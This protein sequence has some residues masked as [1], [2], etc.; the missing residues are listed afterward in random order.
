MDL[1][2]WKGRVTD[3]LRR[4]ARQARAEVERSGPHLLYGTLAGMA[5][6]PVAE[7][8]QGGELAALGA[9]YSLGAGVGVNLLANQVQ[10]WKD[11]ADA[12][13]KLARAA[14]EDAEV[15]A[16]LDTV[17]ARLEV[18]PTLQAALSDDD[19]DWFVRLLGDELRRSGS[20]LVVSAAGRGIAQ[21]G[22]RNIAISGDVEGGVTIVQGDADR[23]DPAALRQAYLCRLVAQTRGLPLIGVDP[24]AASDAD[25]ADLE[26]AAVYTALLTQRREG[27]R[28][29]L[30]LPG[31][32]RETRR[33]SAVEMLNAEPHL[34]L[35]G[36]PG[37]GKSTFVNFVALCLAGEALG[38]GRANVELLTAP[39]PDEGAERQRRTDEELRP[40]PWDH[41]ALLPV[42]V[43]LRDLAARG[44]PP[45]GRRAS[46]DDLWRFLTAEL[47]ETLAEYAPHLKRELQE[48]GGLVLLDGLDE[49]PE[50]DSRREQAKQVVVSFA[51]DFPR[52]RFLVTSRTYAYQ[53]QEWKLP[54]FVEAVLAPFGPGQ[55]ERFVDRWY[56]HIATLRNL[57]PDDA[58]G[59]A[60]VLKMAIHRS[61]RLAD[62]A[63]RPVLLTLMASLHAWRGGS[64]PEKREELYADVVDLLLDQWERAKVVRDARGQPLLQQPSLTEWL[65]VDRQV[66]RSLLNRLAFESHRDQPQL[67]GT[68]DLSQARVVDGLMTAARNPEVNPAQ[69]VVYVRDRAGLLAARGEGV[70]AFPHRSFQ[71]YLAACHLTDHGFPDELA[72]LLRAD[73]E[74]W[75]EVTLLAAAKSARGT[76]FA[77]WSLVDALCYGE[78]SATPA[79]ADFWAALLAARALVETEQLAAVSAPNRAK[80]ERLRCWLVRLVEGG[81]LPPVDRALAGDALAVLGDPRFDPG[82]FWLPCRFR[83]DPELLLGFLPVPAAEFQMGSKRYDVEQ[84]IHPVPLGEYYMARYPVTNAQ[85]AAF[86]QA[87]DREPPR[88]WNGPQPPAAARHHPVVYV[89]WYDA[90]AYSAWLTGQL[91]EGAVLPPPLAAR[92]RDRG[93]VVRLPTEAQWE[94]AA[95]WDAQAG[96]AREWPWGDEWDAALC[97][98]SEGGIGTTTAVGLFPGGASPCGALDMAGNVWEWCQS[99]YKNYPYRAEDGREDPKAG[100]SRVLRGGAFSDFQGRA[101]CAVRGSLHPVGRWSGGG[102]RLVVSPALPSGF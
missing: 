12:G 13:Q 52:C 72:G 73:P 53:R 85:Y 21:V 41:G 100:G 61:E 95:S 94:R 16:A 74:R 6:W 19:R 66:V 91:R 89:S 46:G 28:E 31:T 22:G 48:R 78:P 56:A 65:K 15:R 87:T 5:L 59:Q 98:T 40:Q 27:E 8:V 76:P 92:L 14:R 36:D 10:T 34:V 70:Y 43:V 69:V 32:E 63:T 84:P 20:R 51:N 11:E 81:A 86:V 38:E 80:V 96:Q 3:R 58:Q 1:D 77:V 54:G 83:G 39:L 64:L 26:L 33:L 90:R 45:A 17:L 79:E 62:L 82:A 44:L 4:F 37:S 68:A 23:T 88:H 25:C 29:G 99:L 35:L 30:A 102:F 71:E 67:R 7:A 57:H 9:L 24:K 18:L 60:A 75:R 50:A 93:C 47:G 97:N 2:A 49:V 42:R 55:I 101:R